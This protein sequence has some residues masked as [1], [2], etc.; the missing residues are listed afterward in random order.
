MVHLSLRLEAYTKLSE[1]DRASIERLARKG[2]REIGARRDLVREGDAPK[3]VFLIM[4]GWAC[5]YKQL[6][7]GR[8]QIVS[9]FLPGDICDLNIYI[10]KE[11]DHSIGA[12]T[13]LK[14]AEIGRDEFEQLMQGHP[15]IT[16]AL[17]W[18]QL[19]TVSVQREWTL[20]LGQRTAYERI[21]HLFMELF[22]RLEAVGLTQGNSCDL[23]LTQ[24]DIAD[25]S[26]LTAVHVNRMLQE[27]RK[28]GLIE[29]QGR[30]LTI[31]DAQGLKAAALFNS[32]Y[33]HLDREGAHLDAND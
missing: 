25:A 21:A 33:L 16:Q 17:F 19:V 15:R 13:P 20:N 10:L 12:I 4:E 30:R 24:V 8:R 3:S 2:S 14:V 18:D 26:G 23:P 22:L 6:P 5:R 31:L 32:N 9:L 1:H 11:M 29:L 7:D 28:E 27:L